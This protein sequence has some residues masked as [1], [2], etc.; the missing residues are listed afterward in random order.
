MFHYVRPAAANILTYSHFFPLEDFCSFLDTN[1]ERLS[2]I[3]PSAF[4]KSVSNNRPIP[5][6]T[7]LLS[8]DDGLF[9]HYQWVF[10]ELTKR[11]LS[12]F[13]FINTIPAQGSMLLVHKLHLLS[14]L[15][16]YD[17]MKNIF[18]NR[19][20]KDSFFS[21]ETFTDPLAPAAYPYDSA[22][23]AGFKYALNYLLPKQELHTI[24][25]KLIDGYPELK[26]IAA[27]FYIS[28]QEIAEMHE[29]GMEFG[30][31]GHTHFPFSSLDEIALNEELDQSDAFFQKV[32]PAAPISLSYPYGDTTSINEN[33]LAVLRSR[34][35]KVAFMADDCS[36]V[37]KLT[38][39]RVDCKEIFKIQ[40]LL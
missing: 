40:G 17:E 28:A 15:I 8:F 10:P 31:H 4:I 9:E 26:K 13:F 5:D 23:V 12:G 20:Q 30:Y 35:V 25:D 18:V 37:T 7:Y 16:G 14:G 3:T 24:M 33:N 36:P 22:E 1:L 11:R 38:L 32:L 39:P 21:A 34:G 27:K 29:G 2:R 19:L 6:D